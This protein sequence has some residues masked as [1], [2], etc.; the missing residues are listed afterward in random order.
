MSKGICLKPDDYDRLIRE[1]PGELGAFVDA[2]L[3]AEGYDDPILAVRDWVF[4]DGHG[5]GTKSGLPLLPP[6]ASFVKPY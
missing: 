3:A 5:K 2:I 6:P 1:P 4:D